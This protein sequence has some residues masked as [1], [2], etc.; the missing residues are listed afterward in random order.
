MSIWERSTTKKEGTLPTLE[1]IKRFGG[2][3]DQLISDNFITDDDF[4]Y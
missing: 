3:K 4:Y 1:R 2:D